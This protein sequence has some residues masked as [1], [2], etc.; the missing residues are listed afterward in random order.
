MRLVFLSDLKV[1]F[2][3]PELLSTIWLEVRT[4]AFDC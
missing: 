3:L 2:S 4:I 1:A